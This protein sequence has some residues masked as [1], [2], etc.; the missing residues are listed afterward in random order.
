MI[1]FFLFGS[2]SYLLK[3]LAKYL[4]ANKYKIVTISR[5]KENNVKKLKTHYVSDYSQKSINDILNKEVN[6]FK[7]RPVFIFGN[8][9]TQSDL[10]INLKDNQIEKIINVNIKLPI[11]ILKLII[12]NYLRK[13]PIFF[14]ISSIRVCPGVGY[15]LYGSS[16]S[17]LENL[18]KQLSM[19]YGNLGCIFKSIR[20]GISNG[21]LGVSL[22]DKI[23][24]DYKKR[25][26]IQDLLD[27]DELF[28]T[29]IFEVEKKS[30]NG[31]VIYCDNGYF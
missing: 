8:V 5:K 9:I 31:K 14:N 6:E 18:F 7:D 28:K 4:I 19:E 3:S 25:T 26:S 17:F 2:S 13:K 22:N 10:F 24:S 15:S 1:K 16:K 20:V 23:I 12:K 27:I 30:S 29:L 11:R 21:G